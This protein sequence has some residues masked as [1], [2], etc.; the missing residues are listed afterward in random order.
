MSDAIDTIRSLM[1]SSSNF[2]GS[3]VEEI[4]GIIYSKYCEYKKSLTKL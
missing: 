4:L 1:P 3:D 2:A